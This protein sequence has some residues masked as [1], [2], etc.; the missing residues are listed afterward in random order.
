MDVVPDQEG[1]VKDARRQRFRLAH[2]YL[3]RWNSES[4]PIFD[5]YAKMSQFSGLWR[6]F[7]GGHLQK[8]LK[9][10]YPDTNLLV[11]IRTKPGKVEDLNA[12]L[13]QDFMLVGVVYRN[14][15]ADYM[16]GVFRNPTEPDMQAYAQ[17]M[18]FVPRRRL[19]KSWLGSSRFRPDRSTRTGVPGQDMQVE[20]PPRPPTPPPPPPR[21]PPRYPQE[22][23]EP[24]M[25]VIRQSVHFYPEHWTL[26]NQNWTTQLVPATSA[27]IREILRTTPYDLPEMQVP[28]LAGVSDRD[29]QWLSNH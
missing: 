3:R 28:N 1:Y 25:I 4:L 21:T 9:E 13:E 10:D 18:T 6:I 27:S 24:E 7:T 23:E 14:K 16:P 22:E 15:F 5:G 19:I 17:V 8:L 20:G 2:Q 26:V 12:H 29:F 11:Q